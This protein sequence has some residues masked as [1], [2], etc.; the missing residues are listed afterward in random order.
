MTSYPFKPR[1]ASRLRELQSFEAR[2]P[3]TSWEA[4]ERDNLAFQRHL[5][6]HACPNDI[7]VENIAS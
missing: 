5:A 7:R 3:L 6:R 4:D 1:G 2:R